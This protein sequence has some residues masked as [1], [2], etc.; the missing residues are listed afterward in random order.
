MVLF[1]YFE[2][3]TGPIKDL[4]LLN[5]SDIDIFFIQLFMDCK[6]FQYS[7]LNKSWIKW[8]EHLQRS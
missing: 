6:T 4:L 8:K 1:R 5:V 7:I 3:N 2:D